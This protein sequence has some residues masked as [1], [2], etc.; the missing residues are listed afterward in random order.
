MRLTAHIIEEKSQRR[1]DLVGEIGEVD[2][3]PERTP[4][5][6]FL[7]AFGQILLVRV[8]PQHEKG[9]D[10]HLRSFSEGR[11]SAQRI[12]DEPRRK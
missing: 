7:L 10:D 6:R 8:C 1:P 11:T 3:I 4:N 5:G 12:T 2:R 9:E